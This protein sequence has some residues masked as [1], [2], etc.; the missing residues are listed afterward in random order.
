MNSITRSL[1]ALALV[2]APAALA[3]KWE[4]GGGAGGGF[5]TSQDIS[6]PAGNAKAKFAS[7]VAASAWIANN[8]G[9]FFGGELRYDWQKG[10][11][12]LTSGGTKANFAALTHALHYDFLLH[13]A[14]RSSPVR[15][16]VA[17]G[18]GFK[19]FQGTGEE[20]VF[21]PLS[22]VGLLTRTTE[23][24]PLVS[25]GAGV[26]VKIAPKVALRA[27]VHDFLSPFPDQVIAPSTGAT[28]GGWVHDFVVTFG[29]SFLFE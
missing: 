21:Q 2:T 15:P 25:V 18:G 19:L 23:I 8:N 16:Y 10:D 26:K 24:K 1:L 5:Y 6:A 9:T 17:A 14:P 27:E 13:F 28:V 29:L 22:R 7:N 3:Q 11:A 20:V 12:Q 4:F